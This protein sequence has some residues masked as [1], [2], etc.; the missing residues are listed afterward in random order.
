M[1]R[2][3]DTYTLYISNREKRNRLERKLLK[4]CDITAI[5]IVLYFVWNIYSMIHSGAW[6]IVDAD[7]WT[8]LIYGIKLRVGNPFLAGYYLG[9]ICK[10]QAWAVILFTVTFGMWVDINQDKLKEKFAKSK[11]WNMSLHDL[12]NRKGK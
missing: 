8:D 7:I 5:P 6:V 3:I 10:C 9:E 2:I 12:M 11:F 4:I 1:N